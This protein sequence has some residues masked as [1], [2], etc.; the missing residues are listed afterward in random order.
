MSTVVDRALRRSMFKKAAPPQINWHRAAERTIHP[1]WQRAAAR[2][3][4]QWKR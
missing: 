4:H 2:A 3:I 1:N